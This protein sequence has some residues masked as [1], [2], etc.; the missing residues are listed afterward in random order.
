MQFKLNKVEEKTSSTGKQYTRVNATSAEGETVDASIWPDTGFENLAIGQSIE[1]EIKKSG[2]FINLINPNKPKSGGGGYIKQAMEQKQNSI[3]GFQESKSDSIKI[4][5][6]SRD[7][8]LM[9][10]TMIPF[11]YKEQSE[12]EL[13]EKWKMWRKWFYERLGD[14]PKE[15]SEPFS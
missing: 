14:D 9:V 11:G 7:A 5:S 12:E 1:A 4:S 13:Q 8:S 6:A 2:N 15:F 3:K 10:T